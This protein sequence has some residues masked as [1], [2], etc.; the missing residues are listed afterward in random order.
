MKVR[1][2]IVLLAVV[3][4]AGAARPEEE[5]PRKEFLKGIGGAFKAGN[6]TAIARHFPSDKKVELRLRGMKAGRYRGAQARSLLKT[7]LTRT[8]EP[9]KYKLKEVRGSVGKYET[10][11]RLRVD[12][13]KVKG[14]T[15]VYLEEKADGWLIVGIVEY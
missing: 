4:A 9:I 12:G 11:V 14:T 2:L 13:R 1:A 6:A 3:I 8:V 10:E 7:Y 15:C 5:D